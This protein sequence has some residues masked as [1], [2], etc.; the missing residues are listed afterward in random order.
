M[1]K[2]IKL[3]WDI[4]GPES[5]KTAEHHTRHLNEY[6]EDKKLKNNHTGTE[7]ISESYSIAFMIVDED[8]MLQVRDDLR[9]NRGE[10]FEE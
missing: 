8:E 5:E 6:I 1:S 3:I 9:P 2:K 4:R 7:N 10:W